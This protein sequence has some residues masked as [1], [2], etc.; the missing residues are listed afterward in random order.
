K[1]L[2]FGLAKLTEPAEISPSSATQTLGPQT[3]QGTI[4]GTATYMSP[5]QAEGKK[6]D[7]RSDIFSFGVMLYEMVTGQKAFQRHSMVETLP[8]I[9]GEEPK[10][11]SEISAE[12]PHELERIIGL[13]LRKDPARRSQHMD[14]VKV[15]LEVLKE[16]S[17]SGRITRQ[18]RPARRQG[19]PTAAIATV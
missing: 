10:P 6:V 7:S 16:E 14:D 3:E 11:V 5:E 13:C 4:V 2:D 12:V 1:L 15:E 8:A 19:V 17:D 18:P 9:I